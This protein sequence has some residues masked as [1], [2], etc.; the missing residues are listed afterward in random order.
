MQDE[1]HKFEITDTATRHTELEN[2][3][4]CTLYAPGQWRRKR[5]DR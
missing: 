3:S 2:I 1:L 5:Y 4:I